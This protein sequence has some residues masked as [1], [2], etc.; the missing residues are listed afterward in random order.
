MTTE[1][2]FLQPSSSTTKPFNN[3]ANGT[4]S[5]S[6][7]DS[8]KSSTAVL[9]STEAQTLVSGG[10]AAAIAEAAATYLASPDFSNVFNTST[11]IGQDGTYQGVASSAAEILATYAVKPGD[12]LDFNFNA[13]VALQATEIEKPNKYY[14]LVEQKTSFLVIDLDPAPSNWYKWSKWGKPQSPKIIGYF[15]L[16]GDLESSKQSLKQSLTKSNNVQLFSDKKSSDIDR[17]NGIDFLTRQVSGN[18]RDKFS[19]S[20]RIAVVKLTT[21]FV[22]VTGD[23]LIDGLGRDVTYGTI[24]ND[25]L[26][27]SSRGGKVYASLGDDTLKGSK[28]QDILE[29][30]G[31]NDKLYGEDGN[32]KLFGGDGNDYLEGGSGDDFLIGGSQNDT[33]NGGYGND[34]IVGVDF[35][36]ANAGAYEIDQLS[37]GGYPGGNVSDKFVLGDNKQ[38]YY[39][40]GGNQDYA[41]IKDFA[42]GWDKIWLYGAAGDYT[43][44]YVGSSWGYNPWG[45]WGGGGGTPSDGLASGSRIYRTAGGQKDL[46]GV[47]EN[48][49]LSGQLN[50]SS[51]FQYNQTVTA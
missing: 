18:F 45:S 33:L 43:V 6:F 23:E 5:L 27:A 48:V 13:D 42:K 30:G 31:G 34:K 47:V 9:T 38:A 32:D 21:S 50:S 4:G 46:I 12:T 39:Q 49:N 16:T 28:G 8:S 17:N 11:V 7:Y 22:K 15:G 51:I 1:T 24:F 26:Y 14:S 19:D 35:R 10:V 29:G 25:T 3:V 44:E 40:G 2:L 20:S 36:M 41:L 37:G